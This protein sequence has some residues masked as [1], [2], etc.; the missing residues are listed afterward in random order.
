MSKAGLRIL[1]ALHPA[2]LPRLREVAIDTNA[3]VF[4]LLVAVVSGIAFGLA[5]ALRYSTRAPAALH[6]SRGIS[7]TR[8]RHRTQ[9]VLTVVQCAFAFALLIAAGYAVPHSR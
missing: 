2:N 9:D 4:T 6:G 3:L 5:P 8:E 7:T 1:V